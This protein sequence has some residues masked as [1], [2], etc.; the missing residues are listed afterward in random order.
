MWV[1][2]SDTV[3]V[4]LRWSPIPRHSNQTPG[5]VY[6]DSAPRLDPGYTGRSTRSGRVW[7]GRFKLNIVL[8]PRQSFEWVEM[9]KRIR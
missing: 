5:P 6:P 9:Y 7:S 3:V 8:L 2:V 1:P 4:V